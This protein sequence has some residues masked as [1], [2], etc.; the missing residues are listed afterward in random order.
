MHCLRVTSILAMVRKMA[1]LIALLA[2]LFPALL[3]SAEA[4]SSGNSTGDSW[5]TKAPM[6]QAR[7]GLRAAAVN[8]KIYAIGG[9]G[10]I[11]GIG[12]SSL[13]INEEY[14]PA[15]DT[16]TYKTSMPT[17]RYAFAIAVYKNKLYC[18]GGKAGGFSATGVNEVYDPAADTWR[19]LKPMPT[20]RM[21][22]QANVV[23]GKI[24]LIGGRVSD[25]P[26]HNDTV[27]SLNEAYDPSTNT[28]TTKASM[29]Q[30]AAVYASAAV[31][32]KIYAITQTLNM[33]Y[34]AQ[35]DSWSQ[36]TP[37]PGKNAA[38]GGATTGILAPQRIYVFSASKAQNYD[39]ETDNWT[40][41][42]SIPKERYYADIAVLDDKFYVIGGWT[43]EPTPANYGPS[44]NAFQQVYTG[45]NEVY[46]PISYG[47]APPE[48]VILSPENDMSY[49]SNSVLLNFTVN[50]PTNWSGYSLD[51]QENVSITS[52]TTIADLSNGLHNVT[53]YANDT[54]DNSGTSETIA[55]TINQPAL[56]PTVEIAT[57]A[58]IMIAVIVFVAVYLKRRKPT[59]V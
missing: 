45:V 56:F 20:A 3:F 19:T 24:Y 53:V 5:A 27:F 49:N 57:I 42:A 59:L 55:F 25:Q 12:Y 48:I 35:N 43:H 38:I 21:N 28:W 39:P 23:D 40:D 2:L 36:G 37:P 13:A 1:S 52:N 9:V 8:G 6:H 30:A 34:D 22:L 18:M 31:N 58:T 14:D 26:D 47:A 10:D 17:P 7:I 33:I 11:R 44:V 51:G 46:T 41:S 4:V 50:K 29:P 16:W 15:T 54:P 32:N